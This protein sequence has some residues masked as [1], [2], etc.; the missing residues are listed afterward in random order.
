MALAASA[1]FSATNVMQNGITWTFDKDHSVGQFINGDW[2]V[3]GPIKIIAI[4]NDL[5]DPKFEFEVGLNGAVVN[6]V[7]TGKQGFDKRAKAYHGQEMYNAELNVNARN[8]KFIDKDNPLELAL[9]SSLLTAVSWY[10]VDKE[11]REEKAPVNGKPLLRSAAVLT[12][13]DK[14]APEGAFRPA[15]AGTEKKLYNVKDLKHD[16]LA[17]LE[18][19]TPLPNIAD[20]VK[21]TER[22]WPDTMNGDSA[23]ETLNP[24]ENMPL[25]GFAM[26]RVW[27]P[28]LLVLNLDPGKIDGQ[29]DNLEKLLIQ[30]V[31]HGIDLAGLANTG[32]HWDG[33]WHG[34]GRK[35]VIVFAAQLL[36]DPQMLDVGNWKTRFIEDMQTFYVSEKE[37]AITNSD[38]WKPDARARLLPYSKE[39][40]GMPEW[41]ANEAAAN[42]SWDAF[43]RGNANIVFTE[44]ALAAQIMGAKKVWNHDAFFD[45]ADRAMS[46]SDLVVGEFAATP[47]FKAMWEAYRAK[48]PPVF[49]N[50]K[51]KDFT[52]IFGE[53]K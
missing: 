48:Y 31:Q 10:F 15:F 19:I 26:S 1:T 53:K 50:S 23:M 35:S 39:M 41:A 27:A 25:T 34:T 6:P 16:V 13:L 5:N 21:Q 40:I 29:K 38:K 9:Q 46:N 4:T 17:K 45:Y 2:W 8:D 36:G 43:H 42:A 33:H 18:P 3:V 37:V 22:V 28:A 44:F 20:L 24:L 11:N 32:S 12:V 52:P 7:S 49:D 14:P 30:I 47:F 51:F